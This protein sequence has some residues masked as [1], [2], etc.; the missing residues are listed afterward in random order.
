MADARCDSTLIAR[1]YLAEAYVIGHTK[2]YMLN[3]WS[4]AEEDHFLVVLFAALDA[5]SEKISVRELGFW[6]FLK[7]EILKE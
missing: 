6:N 5:G 1:K 4:A 7:Y 2:I 3:I